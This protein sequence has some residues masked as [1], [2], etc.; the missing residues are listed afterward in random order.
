[1]CASKFLHAK[2]DQLVA[3][4]D[5]QGYA[6]VTPSEDAGKSKGSTSKKKKKTKSGGASSLMIRRANTSNTNSSGSGLNI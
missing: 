6:T 5:S 1:M 4:R 3:E 2:K